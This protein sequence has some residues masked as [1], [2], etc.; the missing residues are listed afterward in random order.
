M[1]L[2][3]I[4]KEIDIFAVLEIDDAADAVNLAETLLE[5][6]IRAMELTLRTPAALDALQAILEN[7][8]EMA[9]GVGTVLT[10]QQVREVKA[11]GAWFA[12]SPGLNRSVIKEA[13]KEDLP[14]CPRSGSALRH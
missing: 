9:A 14:L 3:E 13:I 1:S 2:D 5:G 6:G 4:I 12:V 10:P 7:V 11:K 8:P